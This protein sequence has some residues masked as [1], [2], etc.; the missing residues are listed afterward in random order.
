MKLNLYISDLTYLY[1]LI[2]ICESTAGRLIRDFEA[3]GWAVEW[4]SW[5]ADTEYT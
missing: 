4:V 5:G 2:H 3:S 1:K